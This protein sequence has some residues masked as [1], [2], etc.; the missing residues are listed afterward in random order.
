MQLTNMLSIV[1]I[2]LLETYLIANSTLDF[3][4]LNV[5]SNNYPVERVCRTKTVPIY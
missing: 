4:L 1:E 2:S 5:Q 3:N